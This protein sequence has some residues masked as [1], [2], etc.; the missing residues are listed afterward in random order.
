MTSVLGLLRMSLVGEVWSSD[1]ISRGY[2]YWDYVEVRS[3]AGVLDISFGGCVEGGLGL[4]GILGKT[5]LSRDS[6][7]T[8]KSGKRYLYLGYFWLIVGT[9]WYYWGYHT[10]DIRM[11]NVLSQ[12]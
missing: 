3:R 5:D 4:P 8:W 11:Y 1:S 7:G 9:G 6:M 2:K 12:D 10:R